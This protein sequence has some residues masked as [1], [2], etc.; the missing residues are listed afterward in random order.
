MIY[1]RTFRD[2]A[3]QL[4]V[5]ATKKAFALMIWLT[6]RFGGIAYAQITAGGDLLLTLNS[7]PRERK[8]KTAA[9]ASVQIRTSAHLVRLSMARLKTKSSRTLDS[10]EEYIPV[11]KDSVKLKL[12]IPGQRICRPAVNQN[13]AYLIHNRSSAS[14]KS[15]PYFVKINSSDG[16]VIFKTEIPQSAK[17]GRIL[18]NGRKVVPKTST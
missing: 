11:E 8:R 3:E 1:V 18:E 12:C 17:S 14:S 10:G 7:R 2:S 9:K 6:A 13:E 5:H 4:I 16:F 15:D